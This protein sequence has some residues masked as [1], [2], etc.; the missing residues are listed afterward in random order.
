MA[1]LA[2]RVKAKSGSGPDFGFRDLHAVNI[3]I[4]A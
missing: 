2:V 1:H 4:E 3:K